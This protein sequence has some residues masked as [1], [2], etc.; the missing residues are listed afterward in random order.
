MNLNSLCYLGLGFLSIVLLIYVC[1]KKGVRRSLLLFLAMVGLGYM[2]EAVIYNL[3]GSYQYYP[4]ILKHDRIYD[5][6]M[7]A[8]ASNALAL[9][10]SAT[11]IALFRKSWLWIVS[12]IGLFAGI[13]W[14]FLEL[15]IYSHH[16][17]KIGYTSLGLPFYFLSAKFLLKKM[18]FPIKGKLHSFILFL[19][20]GTFTGSF[21]ILPI[22]LFTNRYYHLGWWTNQSKDTTA[23]GAIFYLCASLFYVG[24]TKFPLFPRWLK[25]VVTPLCM[26]AVNIFLSRIEILHSLVWWDP[27]YYIILSIIAL[28]FTESMSKC[29]AKG[30]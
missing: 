16:W 9:P 8:I 11:F 6:N 10:V 26:F 21:H 19:I 17:W 30:I 13:E 20:V 12:F 23:F 18:D 27:W 1:Y 25:Y 14:L 2:I 7:G 28:W 22:M 4:K 3:L 24:I 15:H 29:I 5:S